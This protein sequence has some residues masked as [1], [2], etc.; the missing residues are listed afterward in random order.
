MRARHR[1]RDGI[2]RL[3]ARIAQPR[4][5]I[6]GS[7]KL[8]LTGHQVILRAVDGTQPEGQGDVRQQVDQWG[9]GR[10][11]LGNLDLIE[12]EL[13]IRTI[14]CDCHDVLPA[15][16]RD[17]CRNRLAGEMPDLFRS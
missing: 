5:G 15:G 16:Q 17:R 4:E 11:C 8:A 12:N 7:A 3:E 6:V 10:V 13:E 1:K 14:K 9:S 2:G